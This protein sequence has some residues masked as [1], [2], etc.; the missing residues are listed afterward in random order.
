[1]S[2][3]SGDVL[4]GINER[5]SFYEQ[6]HKMDILDIHIVDAEVV[7][8][9]TWPSKFQEAFEITGHEAI[10]IEIDKPARHLS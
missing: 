6:F 2:Y 1:M 9:F 4:R 3:V 8:D 10:E 5:V 7:I